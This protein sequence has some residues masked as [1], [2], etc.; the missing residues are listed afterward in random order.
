LSE[1]AELVE[2]FGPKLPTNLNCKLV[3]VK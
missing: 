2:S 1:L 3:Q